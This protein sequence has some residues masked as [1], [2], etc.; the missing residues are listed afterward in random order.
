[1]Q[2]RAARF[3]RVQLISGQAP[4]HL[5][6]ACEHQQPDGLT[7]PFRLHP[8]LC[9]S[10]GCRAALFKAILAAGLPEGVTAVRLDAYPRAQELQLGVSGDA[11][12]LNSAQQCRQPV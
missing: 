4:A 1:M 5:T 8:F 6:P 9:C 7:V 12:W 2:Q 10:R 3:G 11:N